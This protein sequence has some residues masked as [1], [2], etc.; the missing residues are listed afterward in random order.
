M[1]DGTSGRLDKVMAAATI[2]GRPS[3]SILRLE[4][5]ALRIDQTM[6]AK[7]MHMSRQRLD[8]LER[9]ERLT[10]NMIER[11]RAALRLI[12]TIAEPDAELGV[13]R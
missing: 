9:R 1:S 10:D 13:V 8:V 11:Y 5:L 4:R 2:A 3:G 12:V 6:L 7:H